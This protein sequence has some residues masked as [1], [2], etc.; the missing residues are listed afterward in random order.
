MAAPPREV[1]VSGWDGEPGAR[2]SLARAYV[3][4]ARAQAP[5]A[6]AAL[7]RPWSVVQDYRLNGQIHALEHRE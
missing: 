6:R 4:R 3:R 1:L 5:L 2:G 7:S